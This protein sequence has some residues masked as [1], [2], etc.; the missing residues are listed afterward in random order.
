VVDDDEGVR[1][2]A[3]RILEMFG[4]SVVEAVDGR[5]GVRQFAAHS[6]QI[7][8]VLLDMTM[9]E[10]SGEETFREIRTLR[11]DI[12]VILSSG[13]NEIEATRAFT[14]KGLAGFLQKPFTPSDMAA[15][16]K[17]VLP[18]VGVTRK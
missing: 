18:G 3:R 16:V 6:Q 15:K 10:M 11:G 4:F 17:A 7:V 5:D 2:I 12:P 1:R 9:P 8:L 14:A 13:Y